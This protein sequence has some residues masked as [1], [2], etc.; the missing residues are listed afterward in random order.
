MQAIERSH[1]ALQQLILD[2]PV[3]V[4]TLLEDRALVRRSGKASLSQGLWRVRVEK[5]APVL[6]DKSLRAETY[7]SCPRSSKF[8]VST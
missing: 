8:L 2:A 5:V 4:V 7:L 1:S 6:S 3:C